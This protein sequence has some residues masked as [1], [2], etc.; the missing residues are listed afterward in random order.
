MN[1]TLGPGTS[2]NTIVPSRKAMVPEP[3]GTH[4]F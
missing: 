4:R 1:T 3:D 2:T